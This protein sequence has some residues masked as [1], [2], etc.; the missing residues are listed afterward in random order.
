MPRSNAKKPQG[1]VHRT[2]MPFINPK[3]FLGFLLLLAVTFIA[4][5][6]ALHAGYIWDDGAA[7]TN[8]GLLRSSHGLWQIWTD[9]AAIPQ[10]HYWPLVYTTFW[11]E[12]HFWGAAP[13]GYHFNNILLHAINAALLWLILR[14]S[15]I[16][17]AWLAAAVFALHPVH[18]ESVAWVV[19]RKNVLSGFFYLLSFLAWLRFLERR[20]AISYALSLVM[21]ICAMLSKSAAITFPLALLLWAW[22]KHGKLS[23]KHDGLPSLP[24]FVLA[25]GLAA[26]DVWV[27]HYHS[28][29]EYHLSFL[30]RLLIAGLAPW[31]YAGK[32][33]W[34]HPLLAVY[35]LWKINAA[36]FRQY[37]W[38]LALIILL[39]T[40][41]LCRRRIGRG[42]VVAVLFFC[43]SLGPV[44]GFIDFPFMGYSYV[45]DHFQYLPSIGLITLFVA[46]GAVAL[47]RQFSARRLHIGIAAIL[48]LSLGCLT[49]K[50]AAIYKNVETLFTHNLKYNPAAWAAHSNLGSYFIEQGRASE[51]EQHFTEAIRLNPH[52]DVSL[53]GIGILL[54]KRGEY[55][56]AIEYFNQAAQANAQFADAFAN[57]A[58][59]LAR[60][61]RHAEALP[62][63]DKAIRLQSNDDAT[64]R[65]LAMSLLQLDRPAEAVEHL[66]AAL[67]IAPASPHTMNHLAWTLATHKALQSTDALEP[68]R[69][70]QQAC[71]LTQN[72]NAMVL[73]TLAA[74]LAHVGQYA[75]AAQKENQ[76]ISIAQASGDEKLINSYQQRLDLYLQNQPYIEE[77][78]SLTP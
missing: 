49:W 2:T 13:L 57:S 9:P 61:G 21:F 40:L 67:R 26:F 53:N 58:F 59:A 42:P 74:A 35:P 75:E 55:Q 11:L 7:V 68:V 22:R 37:P 19:E 28:P 25:A 8:N 70:A 15:G 73:D 41:F 5:L 23:L 56:Q 60:L 50:Q 72:T 30:D 48:L 54:A 44:L 63:Y 39:I 3:P 51:A 31:F 43:I 64:H 27:M 47:D 34:P 69:L 16:P 12:Y 78:S 71:D 66:R 33:L 46:T 14:R 52:D 45:A 17:G 29:G 32:L 62:E 36:D 65:K 10:S 1:S 20:G 77:H 24:F 38:P 76:A 4:Y 18:V 6:P